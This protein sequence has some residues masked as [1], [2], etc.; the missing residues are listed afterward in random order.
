MAVKI[1]TLNVFNRM[2]RKM[3]T[4][5]NNSISIVNTSENDCQS[6]QEC[7]SEEKACQ[8]LPQIKNFEKFH[9]SDEESQK[10]IYKIKNNRQSVINING[11]QTLNF[12]VKKKLNFK[13]LKKHLITAGSEAHEKSKNKFKT[14]VNLE[15]MKEELKQL[16]DPPLTQRD[17]DLMASRLTYSFFDQPCEQLAQNLLGKIL[18][19]KLENG[20]I[21]KGRIV[22]TE[23]YLGAIDKASHT[24]QYRV[25]ARNLP[26]YMPPG[27]IYV[28]FTYGMY[29]CFNLSSQEPDSQVEIKSIE[30]LKGLS[31]MELLLNTRQI[32]G[33]QEKEMVEN[34]KN[35]KT[36]DLCNDPGDGCAVLVRALEPIEGIEEMEKNRNSIKKSSSKKLKKEFISHELCNGPSKLCMAYLLDKGHSKYSLCSWKGLWLEEDNFNEEKIKIIKC[37][38]IGIESCGIEW[39]NK[40]L[41]YYIH[42]NKSVSKR[43]KIAEANC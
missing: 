36:Q 8:N 35:Y 22:E 6:R 30:P 5:L 21:L 39:A 34:I 1:Q 10:I 29:Y 2:K 12:P 42:N 11:N 4:K 40:P 7:N 18:V 3:S 14:V 37:K 32:K 41:R 13:N 24:Y 38:R 25:S 9:V 43:D 28:Y 17:K 19:R 16:E 33:Q 15:L 23:S 26:M 31:Y 27:T 20:T